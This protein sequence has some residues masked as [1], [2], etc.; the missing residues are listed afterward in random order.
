LSQ[1]I[2]ADDGIEFDGRM[3]ED[4]PLGGAETATV[5]LLNALAARGNTVAAFTRCKERVTHKGVR[6]IPLSEGPPAT[7]DLY[8]ANRSWRLI[9]WMPRARRTVF[10]I[11]NPAGYLLKPRYLTRLFRVRPPIVFS[12]QSHRN[13]YPLWAPGRRVIIPYGIDDLFRKAVPNNAIPP[14]RAIFTSNPLRGLDWLLEVWQTRIRP[15]VPNAELHVFSGAAVYGGEANPKSAAM[16]AVLDRAKNLSPAGVVL[17]NPVSKPEL[18]K[19]ILAS[20]VMLYRGDEGETFC[21]AVGEAQ[22]AGLP[23]VVLPIASLKERVIDGVTG[24]IATDDE[25]FAEAAV[26]I[27]TD[28]ALWRRHHEGALEHQRKWSWDDAAFQFELLIP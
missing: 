7:A 20:R 13:T 3:A 16:Q 2:L 8:I 10:W 24:Q 22:A 18:L 27:L 21:L 26:S 11:H 28:D 9:R 19:E 4:Q 12:G 15:L 17:R 5:N 14:P 25:T 1:F 23:A 6:W